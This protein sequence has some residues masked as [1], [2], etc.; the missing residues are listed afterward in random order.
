MA[1]RWESTEVNGEDMKLYLSM[2]EGDGPCPAV[3]V[4]H[5]G[6]GLDQFSQYMADRLAAAGYAGVAPDLFHRITEST[7][8]DGSRPISHMS[9]PDIVAD[10]N[11][12]VEYIRGTPSIDGQRLGVTGFCMGGRITYLAAAATPHF[13][14][15]VPYYGGNTMV[16]WGQGTQTP[17]DLSSQIDCPILF[18]FGELDQNPSQA[19]MAKLDAELT[20]LGKVHQFHTYP[21]ADHA[22]MDHTGQRYQQAAAE[23]SWPRTLEFFATHL[24]GVAVR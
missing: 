19:D 17:F 6:S 7:L 5:H 12:T 1:S 11:A 4:I 15:A 14:G 13:K 18:H 24:Q 10:L 2:P 9:D 23:A 21:G 3:V 20:R 16:T 8:A 22:F